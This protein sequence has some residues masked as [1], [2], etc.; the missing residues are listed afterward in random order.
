MA[1]GTM[2]DVV[3]DPLRLSKR[4]DDFNW[5]DRV[6]LGNLATTGPKLMLTRLEEG[7]FET[8][9]VEVE[10]VHEIDPVHKPVFN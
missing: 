2:S 4:V 5:K 7:R 3:P 10:K 9:R 8:S 6:G 1:S